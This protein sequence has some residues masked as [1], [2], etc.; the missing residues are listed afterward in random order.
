MTVADMGVPLIP[1]HWRF[2][3]LWDTLL[4]FLYNIF[5][6]DVHYVCMLVQR[7]EPQGRRFTNLHYDYYHFSVLVPLLTMDMRSNLALRLQL[8]VPPRFKATVGCSTS[9]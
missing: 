7:F 3:D 9:L 1:P 8:A 6:L 4:F 5:H 2:A